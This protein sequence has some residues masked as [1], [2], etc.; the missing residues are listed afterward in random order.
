MK[1][2]WLGHA[3]FLIETSQGTKLVTDPYESGAY[4]GAV[5]YAPIG[6]VPDVV[7]VSHYHADHGYVKDV[8]IATVVDKVGTRTIKDIE[9]E[10]IR[11]YHDKQEGKARGENTI[12]IIKADNV[13]IVHF[14][15]LGT[16]DI[17]YEKI[18][19][20]DVALIPVGGTFTL[21]SKEATKLMEKI[22][23]RIVIPMHFKTPKLG[24]NIEGVEPFLKGKVLI[25]KGMDFIEVRED[26][27]P[28][29]TKVA[30]LRFL[31]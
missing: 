19:S 8:A 28:L 15:D 27:L 29:S 9:V 30:V 16:L 25:G 1:I 31:R 12:F 5:G 17:E 24:F 26:T 7:T 3:S 11:S 23:P 4:S 2:S 21:D 20:P 22:K 6:I 14:G 18:Q 10:G 13:S